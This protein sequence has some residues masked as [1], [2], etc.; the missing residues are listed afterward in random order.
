MIAL[1]I[2][3][4]SFLREVSTQKCFSLFVPEPRSKRKLGCVDTGIPSPL[5]L[6]RLEASL[7]YLLQ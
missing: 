4:L 7:T 1:Y 6:P 3:L 2:D 5:Y